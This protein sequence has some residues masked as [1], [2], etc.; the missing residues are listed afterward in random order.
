MWST[1]IIL[2]MIRSIPSY[3]L[4]LRV[5]ICFPMKNQVFANHLPMNQVCQIPLSNKANFSLTKMRE[6]DC[7]T[8][9]FPNHLIFILT[10][11][12]VIDLTDHLTVQSFVQF[13]WWECSVYSVSYCTLVYLDECMVPLVLWWCQI[14]LFPFCSK[15]LLNYTQLS[16]MQLFFFYCVM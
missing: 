2:W 10:L 12:N 7:M 3:L 11:I 14:L 5:E 9:C 8:K 4:D 6:F 15:Q 13:E 1:I 16:L